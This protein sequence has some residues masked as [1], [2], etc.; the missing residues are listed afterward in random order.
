MQIQVNISAKN[1]DYKVFIDELQSIDIDAKVA[2]ITNPTVSDLHLQS[3]KELI[4][5][6]E[7]QVVTIPDG[8]Q[9]KHL[10]TVES[11]LNQLFEFH[12]NRHS[13]LIALGGGVIGDITG[14]CASI[15]ER[16][17]K[18]IQIPTTL[19]AQVDASVGGKTGVNNRYGK[20]LIG[21]FFQPSAVYCQT[22]F[23][24]TLPK[25]EFNSG[26]AEIIKMAVMFDV[27]FFDWLEKNDI[28]EKKNLSHAVS[29]CVQLKADVVQ[30]DEK[31]KGMR[32]V[33]NYGHTFAHVVETLTKYE[34]FL[35]GEAVAIGINMANHLAMELGLLNK[36]EHKRVCDLCERYELPMDFKVDDV[37]EFYNMLF[38]DKKS[39]DE[40]VLFVL[41]NGIGGYK[42]RDDLSKDIVTK[43]LKKF[44]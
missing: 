42:L 16:G 39:L 32:V 22:Q 7:L 18:F 30:K 17:I 40:N 34:R 4:N 15:Y 13:Y 44:T 28:R 36:D 37:E 29:T 8:E 6:K 35:H 14:F 2:I 31:E 23:L 38:L 1:T 20:N 11:I 10:Q 3:V 5:A 43:T 24:D 25:R 41:P 19:L 21:S 9:Y 12:F 27:D 33:L 26:V